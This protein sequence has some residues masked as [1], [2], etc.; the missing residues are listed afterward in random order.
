MQEG[1]FRD[2]F[3]RNEL[4]PNQYYQRVE[5]VIGFEVSRMENEKTFSS[6]GEYLCQLYAI[7]TALCSSNQE[8]EGDE[9]W[10]L[11]KAST[12]VADKL[13]ELTDSQDLIASIQESRPS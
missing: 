1:E 11:K 4:A 8:C 7:L 3:Y 13:I 2:N 9:L 5:H 6:S 10:Q 12:V